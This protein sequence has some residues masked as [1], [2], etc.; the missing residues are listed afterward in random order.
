VSAVDYMHQRN[1]VHRDIKA[2]NVFF[3]QNEKIVKL[4]D[5]GFA[6]QVL[7]GKLFD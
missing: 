7:I 2:E 4:G 5:F 1:F 6:T 3:G